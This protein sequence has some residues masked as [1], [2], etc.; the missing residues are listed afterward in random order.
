M[1]VHGEYPGM[2]FSTSVQFTQFA[3]FKQFRRGC[4]GNILE[5]YFDI[6][7]IYTIYTIS[8]RVHGEYP[9]VIFWLSETYTIYTISWGRV[10]WI[11]WNNIW[12]YVE[13]T[14]FLQFTQFHGCT[15][16]ISCY[17]SE[18]YT[19]TQLNKFMGG[20]WEG[21]DI[22]EYTISRGYMGNILELYF[23]FSGIYTLHNFMGGVL[24]HPGRIFWYQWNL[25]CLLN[26]YSIYTI[27][28]GGDGEYLKMIHFS[29]YYTTYI[30]S[31]VHGNIREWYFDFSELYT[32]PTIYTILWG[33][34]K[35][36]LDWY[37]DISEIYTTAVVWLSF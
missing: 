17:F 14:Q 26:R 9:G 31:W 28:W 12:T 10:I 24:E 20:A 2:I 7:E 23:N 11:S 16:R 29:E 32:I 3:Q 1:V 5:W 19:I 33:W 8:L 36:I 30:I 22:G 34:M 37:F 35:N 6:N 4:M 18:I 13:I 15:W 27:S 25:Q 21:F